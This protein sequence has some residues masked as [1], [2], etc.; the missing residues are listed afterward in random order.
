MKP[1]NNTNGDELEIPFLIKTDNH[2]KMD[3][4]NKTDKIEKI[5]KTNKIEKIDKIEKPEKVEKVE[6]PAKVEKTKKTEAKKEQP[7]EK[8]ESEVIQKPVEAISASGEITI[9]LKKSLTD[10]EQAVLDY[11]KQN[12]GETVFAKDLADLLNLKR[13]YIY[14]YIKNLRAKIVEDILHNSGQGGFTL[15]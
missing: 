8:V 10:R 4:T 3:K 7:K 14:K 6:K 5:D 9:T 12:R 11:L 2:D 13:D 15:K 1:K